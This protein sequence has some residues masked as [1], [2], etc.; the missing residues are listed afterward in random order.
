[1]LNGPTREPEIGAEPFEPG[2]LAGVRAHPVD[3]HD[4]DVGEVFVGEDAWKRRDWHLG[5]VILVLLQRLPPYELAWFRPALKAAAQES[6]FQ[7]RLR[8]TDSRF[9]FLF[10]PMG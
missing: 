5:A 6:S 1:L 3:R 8:K 9:V 7:R 10:Q 2:N 4:Q